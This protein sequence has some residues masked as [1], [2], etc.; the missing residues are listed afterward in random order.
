MANL[1]QYATLAS[2]R[3]YSTDQL[4]RDRSLVTDNEDDII[5][6]TIVDQTN[7]D[8]DRH[9]HIYYDVCNVQP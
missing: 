2:D 4:P 1:Y 9:D 7:Y 3:S 5:H 8:S 6:S